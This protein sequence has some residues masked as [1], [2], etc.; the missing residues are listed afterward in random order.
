MKDIE[1]KID[2]KDVF[3]NPQSVPYRYGYR[4]KDCRNNVYLLPTGEIIYF[5]AAVVVLYNLEQHS[6]RH[7]LE[8][9]DDIKCLAVHPDRITI[10]TG[11]TAG[12]GKCDGK[13]CAGVNIKLHLPCLNPHVRIWNS[14][15][16]ETLHVIGLGIFESSVACLAFSKTDGGSVL[17]VID[18]A[19][20]HTIT[21]WDWQKSRRIAETKVTRLTFII[22]YC[23][24][25][26]RTF[27]NYWT[28][29]MITVF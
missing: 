29:L 23:H 27:S 17:A 5:I 19:A 8:H 16:L 2:N 28:Q 15:S 18:E 25:L 13:V 7:Y 9:N 14:V 24:Y 4:G 6:Q 3:L 26:H 21:V 10:A 1:R 20:N 12:H 22:I 11:Q